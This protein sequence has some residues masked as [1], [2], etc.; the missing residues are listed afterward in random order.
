MTDLRKTLSEQV[1]DDFWSHIEFQQEG[2]IM[3]WFVAYWRLAMMF[4]SEEDI[5]YI[6]NMKSMTPERLQQII[7]E[8]QTSHNPEV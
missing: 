2:C 8:T 6:A 4:L 5:E 1:Y 7:R 3:D